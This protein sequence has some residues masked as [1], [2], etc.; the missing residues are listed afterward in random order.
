MR[1]VSILALA[2]AL[3]TGYP[4]RASV[5]AT[6]DFEDGTVE[7]W[8]SFN[9]PNTP[10]NSTAEASSGTHS[11][12]DTTGSS[13]AGGPGI[14]LSSILSPGA[15]YTIAG[16][17]RLTAGEIATSANFTIRRSDPLCSGG[18]CYDTVGNYQVPVSASGWSQIGG[19]YTVSSTET[20]LF[21]YAQLIGST[22]AQSFYLDDV[23][24][25]QTSAAAP[26][27]RSIVLMSAPLIFLMLLRQRLSARSPSRQA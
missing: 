23:V 3:L 5:I 25:D 1:H 14:S 11:L 6:Y 9:T 12:L 7:G 13:G 26:E 20:V 19:T 27:P 17:V 4:A 10:V 2:F 8:A 15:A 16:E 18:T 22:T 24:I 21:L